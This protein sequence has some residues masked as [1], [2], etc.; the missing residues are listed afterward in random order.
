M[1]I[2][3]FTVN[4]RNSF[5]SKST[6]RFFLYFI[7][8]TIFVC[9][10]EALRYGFVWDDHYALETNYNFRGFSYANITWMFETFYDGNYHPLSWMSFALDYHLWGM[11]PAGY[12]ATN[13]VIH[14]ANAVIFFFLVMQF[15]R[16][17]FKEHYSD[18]D[19]KKILFCAITGTLFHA[20]HPL[21]VENVAWLSARADLLCAAF[22]MLSISFYL[23]YAL[24]PC[25]APKAIRYLLS[26]F[27]CVL[28]LLSRAWGM[29]LPIVL[30]IMDLYPLQRIRLSGQKR[31]FNV[32]LLIEKIPFVLLVTAAG[33]LA[34]L[35]KI[36]QADMPNLT[37]HG[38]FNR[39]AQSIYGLCF[40][41]W[42]TLAPFKLSPL[43]RLE[44]NLNPLEFKYIFCIFLFIAT[45]VTLLITYKRSK[46]IITGF[47]CFAVIVS[48]L[49]GLIQAG[50][51]IVAERYTYISTMPFGILAGTGLFYFW[52]RLKNKKHHFL[53]ILTIF[54]ILS[55]LFLFFALTFKQVRIWHDD[56][57]LW[58]HVISLD[59]QCE[60]AYWNRGIYFRDN[61]YFAAAL[62]DFSHVIR[63]NPTNSMAFANRGVMKSYLGDLKGAMEDFNEAIKLDPNDSVPYANRGIVYATQRKWKKA[64]QSFIK[65][66]EIS[67]ENDKYR[68]ELERLKEN[69]K[70]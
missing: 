4:A 38:I 54:I 9:Y 13:I 59:P 46:G 65:A 36:E 31:S 58:T 53:K 11:N 26:I 1:Q 12:H 5:D 21:R 37:Q 39:I 6:T 66:N 44:K 14:C 2:N 34:F 62:S 51:Q 67:P 56:F 16:L 23:K 10:Q 7:I 42:K 8:I 43:H 55:S 19:G 3:A 15:I 61:K 29:T 70:K 40:Y 35:A 57:S 64:I 63:L 49:L 45:V 50:P 25:P 60:T 24:A 30:I 48:P 68:K 18:T 52:D 32:F 20:L 27:F 69:L 47:G 41:A 22:Y 17:I 28:S 33:Y